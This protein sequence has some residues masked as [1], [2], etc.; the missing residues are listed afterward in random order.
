MVSIILCV[1]EPQHIQMQE[2][3]MVS[4]NNNKKI[5]SRLLPVN[6]TTYQIKYQ[7]IF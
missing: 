1:S 2:K 5:P 6:P 4:V 7:Q 3:D